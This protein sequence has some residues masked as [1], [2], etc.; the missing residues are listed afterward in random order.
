MKEVAGEK[1]LCLP[2]LQEKV[3]LTGVAEM[4]LDMNDLEALR[5]TLK[6]LGPEIVVEEKV[7]N[8]ALVP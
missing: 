6:F 2:R 8:R 5:A 7:A 3:R 4:S 1:A